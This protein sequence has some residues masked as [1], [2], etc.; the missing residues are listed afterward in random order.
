MHHHPAQQLVAALSLVLVTWTTFDAGTLHAQPYWVEKVG[1]AGNDVVSSVRTAADGSIFVSGEFS[2]SITVDG[3][4]VQSG[5][6][7][8]AFVARFTPAG[9][10]DWIVRGG[11]A[12]IDRGLKVDV[13]PN[14][15]VAWVGEFT[16]TAT[17]GDV[18]LTSQG[19]TADMFIALLDAESGS[20]TWAARG[21]GGAGTDRPS[22]VSIAPDGS[23]CV[24]GEF[25]GAA[26]WGALS[27]TSVTDPSTGTPSTDV[28]VAKY[29][30][31]GEEI[32]VEQG[33]AKFADRAVDVA[34]D[35]S[36]NIY[37][38]GQFSD[39]ITFDQTHNNILLNASFLL[40]YDA[41]GNEQWFRR[42]G[43]AGFNHV[44]D[45]EIDL[46]GDLLLT[47]DQQGTMVFVGAGGPV[48]VADAL[49]NAYYVLR[50]STSGALLDHTTVGSEDA[51]QVSALACSAEEVAVYGTFRCQFSDLATFYAG[52]GLFMAA[53]SEDLFIARHTRSNLD[54][55]E[56]QQFGGRATKTSGGIA[57]VEPDQLVFTGG[58]QNALLF[59]STNGFTGQISTPGSGIIGTGVSTYCNDNSYGRYT[60][61]VSEGVV[62]GFVSRGYVNGRQP[63][64]IWRRTG[65][66][67]DRDMLEVCIR[68]PSDDVCPDTIRNCGPTPLNV[69]T[70]Y[71]FA[72]NAN[73]N[74]LGPAL[75]YQWSTGST[76]AQI[77]ANTSGTYSVTVT[78]VNGCYQW[79]DTVVVV[80]LP[81][82]PSPLVSDDVVVN[83]SSSTPAPLELC[84]PETAWVWATTTASGAT[85]TWT[86]PGGQVL[87]GADSV[88]VDTTGTYSF[89]VEAANGCL[90]TVSIEVDDIPSVPLPD[91]D[92]ELEISFP[93]DED[94]NDTLALC[95]GEGV[96]F[97]YTPSWTING[98]SVDSLPEGLTITWGL[99]PGEPT[100]VAN[101]EPQT[102]GLPALNGWVIVDLIVQVSNKPCL[103]DS[104]RFTQRDSIFVTFFP[105]TEVTLDLQGPSVICDGEQII[106]SATC[107]LCEA[108]LWVG[109]SFTQISPDSILV[110]GPGTFSVSGG[111]TDANGCSFGASDGITVT[112]PGA[113]T[114]AA[115]PVD[116]IICP[117]SS[118][119]LSTGSTG[120]DHIW[121]GPEG[122][123]TGQGATLVTTVPG[124]YYLIMSVG[125]CEVTSNPV[126]LSNYGTPFL[127]APDPS[128]LCGPDDEL[129]L[130]VV[131]V[132]GAVITWNAPFSGSAST[133]TI[134]SPGTYSVSVSACG[135]IT[136]LSTTVIADPAQVSLL[137]PGPFVLCDGESVELEATAQAATLNWLPSG[138][139]GGTLLVDASG[140]FQVV[141]T[142]A[143][144]CTD[145]SA[146][147]TVTQ[148]LFPI[149]V[150]VEDTALCAGSVLVLTALG[151]GPLVWFADADLSTVLGNGMS[152]ALSQSA[153]S[154]VY[155]QQRAQGCIG[156]L[157]SAFI[158]VRP[159][160]ASVPII[161]DIDLCLGD[162]LLLSA[163]APAS[164]ELNWSTPGGSF[165]GSV[166]S[167]VA[168]GTNAAGVY[169]LTPAIGPCQG[170]TTAVDVSINVPQQIELG[171][172]VELCAGGQEVLLLPEGFSNVVWST[173]A[174]GPSL[175]VI[176]SALIGV[177]AIDP[178]GCP[179]A[180][181]IAVVVADC[182][183]II[184]NVYSPNGDGW[185]DGWLAEG[186]FTEALA[187]IY[188]RWGN[189]VYEGD[190]LRK[191]W[192]GK[193]ED[194]LEP[195]PEGVYYYVIGF[196]RSDGR[197]FER[198][199]YLQLL[200]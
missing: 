40:R 57:F 78:S 141:A 142:N 38:T 21:G 191:P 152:I 153:S 147:I 28:F 157:D 167:L 80:I 94:G 101:A 6:S 108:L 99:A 115:D 39:T 83:T 150:S 114:I 71:S 162:D 189:V 13:H 46:N 113:F 55:A 92:V 161:G 110:N 128:A 187:T 7:I 85:T 88:L 64:D 73:A 154:T 158:L 196:K 48:N 20:V 19:G 42:F 151:T 194:S 63:Y 146:V 14:G 172:E 199:G 178:N 164:T 123:I 137:T 37:V 36:G 8:D 139:P 177:T 155:V 143:S 35:G 33:S 56:A 12:G 3:T 131:A 68:Q 41:A 166:L 116:G 16:G 120:T 186:G 66:G 90:R 27:L 61:I 23:V 76:A 132:P 111:F 30:A 122:P 180:Q 188:G 185:N 9:E 183:L 26:T 117:N 52:D 179:V 17:F 106:L 140:T 198:A 74:F 82:P 182:D 129:I 22:G 79:Q 121:Y 170:P 130:Q 50:V 91:I 159:S 43:G 197:R 174:T 156:G 51:V 4:S 53:G 104:I 133:Q 163:D 84:D 103:E 124:E 145:T 24:A 60:G 112:T 89:I 168:P 192:N 105:A 96:E 184:P 200:R 100:T 2:G 15:T 58:Y 31:A 107:D 44:R 49:P 165:S 81:L 34:H 190:L 127:S 87:V 72:N 59:P 95:P 118:A 70:N 126:A 1:G 144:G 102:G 77:N 173:G 176:S 134:D 54:L 18:Q 148:V 169:S 25:R 69:L 11:G 32:W 149:P 29:S 119:T 171:P 45:L 181:E 97:Q 62:D 86:T 98:L 193:H 67:C 47:G 10:L 195:C 160:P 5:G 109:G 125:G 93:A 65:T 175:A 138:T 135:I 136:E 75:T